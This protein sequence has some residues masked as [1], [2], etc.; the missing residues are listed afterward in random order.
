M[1]ILQVQ[2]LNYLFAPGGAHKANRILAE[3]LVE[4]GHT[5]W[6]VASSLEPG[7]KGHAQLLAELTARGIEIISDSPE[8]VVFVYKGVRVH[9]V[10]SDFRAYPRVLLQVMRD[11]APDWTLVS[12]DRTF[13][14]LELALEVSPSRVV[15]VSH[16]QATLPF[17]PASFSPDSGRTQLLQRAAGIISVSGYLQDYLLRWG[18]LHSSVIPFPAYGTGPFPHF[19][20][21]DRGWVTMINPSA[22][23]GLCIFEGLARALP[24]VSFAA[25]PTWATTEADRIT[26]RQLPN[27]QILKSSENVDDIFAQTRILLAPSLWGESFGQIVVEAM[28][29]GI[30]VLASQ[31]GGLPEAKLGVDY[32]L[33][34]QPIERYE[35]RLDEQW[36]PIPVVPPQDI[37]P[38]QTTLQALLTNRSHYE[39]LSL[40]SRQAALNFVASL[41]IAPFEQYLESLTPLAD[42]PLTPQQTAAPSETCDPARQ[43]VLEQVQTLSP[44]R[45][46]LL[47][48]RLMH[49]KNHL[50]QSTAIA[51]LPRT[52][53]EDVF[54]LSFAQQRVWFLNQLEPDS[55]FYN[56]A[57]VFHLNGCLNPLALEQS[58]N[59]IV[60]RHEVLR[61][62][63]KLIDD[64]PMQII[65][66][67]RPVALARVD[68]RAWP[69]AE[70]DLQAQQCLQAEGKRLFDLEHD[71][72]FRALLLQLA[73]ETY[74]LLLTIHH[75]ICDGWSIGILMQ[76]LGELYRAFVQGTPSPL[77]ELPIQYA[78]FADWQRKYLQDET[79]A[80]LLG[81]WQAQFK[82]ALP[83]LTLPTDRPR[84]ANETYRGAVKSQSL[85]AALIA[86][87]DRLSR[88][89][90]ATLFM[91][92]LAAFLVL[93]QRYS[94]QSDLIV[95]TPIANRNR[96]GIEKLIGFFVNI[97]PLRVSLEGKPTF[98]E[99]IQRTRRV[100]LDA[101]THQ[102]LP[103]EKL[104]EELQL[105]RDLSHHPLFQVMF[106]AQNLPIQSL[107]QADLQV[108]FWGELN[109]GTAKFDLTLLIAGA[110]VTIEYNTDLFE[111]T[112]I[113]R[114]LDHYQTLLE[115]GLAQPDRAIADL[116]LLSDI[117]RRQLLVEW[118]DTLVTDFPSGCVHAR[119]AAQVAQTPTA[120][121]VVFEG[122][123]LSYSELNERA[124]QLAHYLLVQGVKTEG[125]VGI[126]VERSP[127]MIVGML[128]ILKAGGTYV[129]LDPAYPQERLAFIV[130]DAQVSVV[131]T[132]HSLLECLPQTRA[133][134]VCL[135]TDWEVIG[136]MPTRTPAS[137]VTPANTAYTIYTSGSTGK[138]KGVQVLH[139]AV[140]NFLESMRQRPGL[141]ASDCLL[142][143]TTFSFDIA[144][145]EIFLPLMV[146]AQVV[147]V[148][149]ATASDGVQLQ[150]MIDHSHATV[151]QATPATW[152]LLLE[153][154]WTGNPQ[155]KILCGGEALPHDLA[156]EL[157]R[158]SASLWN[159]YGP[160]E[161][162]IWSC[163]YPVSQG[164]GTVPIG[165]PIAN[166]EIY[167]LDQ[168][169]QPVPIGV[170]GELHIGGAGLA[171][172][173]WQ[174]PDLTAEKFTPHP[175]SQQ[176]GA[177]LYK[178][179]DLACYL[180]DGCL[181]FLGRSDHQ[182]KVRGYRIE[183]GE[184]EAMLTQQA[185]IR[186]AVVVT[187]E[188]PALGTQ[189]VA[190]VVSAS[191]EAQAI[192][193]LKRALRQQLPDY[194][195]PTT[196]IVLEALPLTPNGKLDRRALPKPN[197]QTASTHTFIA[198]RT[199]YEQILAEVWT[200]VLSSEKIGVL[201]NFFELGGHSLLA[202]RVISR[203]RDRFEVELPVRYIFESPTIAELALR[204]EQTLIT[205][206]EALNEAEVE[207]LL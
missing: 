108:R 162:T 109:T 121:A 132:Q 206:I 171:R 172:G 11:F 88:Q 197:R 24:E 77:P 133:Q 19:G 110:E 29:R 189:L 90:N 40:A 65:A 186:Q 62:N 111:P 70:R 117:E 203:V 188:E 157:L 68:L 112:T 87:L 168:A 36:L 181:R 44:Q 174:R 4:R 164:E 165:R 5:C 64:Q 207:L 137:N 192:D 35:Q 28:L 151:M 196:F 140:V 14:L 66:S 93:L 201:D 195:I 170:P 46:A 13:L 118:N 83:V 160:T 123:E 143:V 169:G 49:K 183:L 106:V 129:P 107:Q 34:V 139:R 2:F 32:L 126:C 105:E 202:T 23:K 73:D 74:Q 103:L 178:T 15:Y 173:Y 158:R 51:R 20:S 149:R 78:D 131:L 135:D 94:G 26:L 71:L 63:F 125:R 27:V 101:Y 84:P 175:F 198:P 154:G 45:R 144:A 57:A 138:P 21:F 86:D 159:L 67:V 167:L 156:N 96:Q 59:A 176:A 47:A 17:G 7:S 37:G 72:L 41:G 22:I 113:Q 120:V 185:S 166:T 155:L 136:G 61:T 194:M 89:E 25:V 153:A 161:T 204:V 39:E 55:P 18:G 43:A 200:D 95:G 30:P 80:K 115:T 52:T 199:P 31:L 205:E 75:S 152:R 98:R 148:S 102:D 177:R 124:N 145:L 9:T 92:Q 99:L 69:R 100:A 1:K 193:D 191:A 147:L 104:I 8:V 50:R 190:Y 76:E 56:I 60:Q 54:P 6:V 91:T 79:L 53:D 179:G 33:P 3:G 182:V 122:Q 146:G 128:G 127:E 163:L 114:L 58:L 142:S 16:S 81:Y 116:P 141:R 42:L 48:L 184:I 12:E 130:E 38:W 187:Y 134:I 97:L 150:Q 119:I 82:G 10:T 180:P 85:P